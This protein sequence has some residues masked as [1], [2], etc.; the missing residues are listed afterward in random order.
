MQS[1]YIKSIR[2]QIISKFPL[3]NNN[4]NKKP[5]PSRKLF[6]LQTF[7]LYLK[8][9]KHQLKIIAKLIKYIIAI[10]DPTKAKFEQVE[11]ISIEV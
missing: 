11:F 2:L 10:I 9:N 7:K 6:F 3:Q 1:E 5:L 4:Q 8:S